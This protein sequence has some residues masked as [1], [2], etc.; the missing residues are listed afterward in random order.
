MGLTSGPVGEVSAGV[1]G[2]A[3]AM[4]SC[5]VVIPFR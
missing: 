4:G 5:M 2:V 3:W 1:A